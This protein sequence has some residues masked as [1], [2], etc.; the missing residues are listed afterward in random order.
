[1]DSVMNIMFIETPIFAKYREEYMPDDIFQEFEEYLSNNPEAGDIV[2]GTGGC[3]KI[4]WQREN[5]GKSSG[6]R[7][8]YYYHHID[9]FILL[10][11]IYPKSKK[12]SLNN[13]EKAL[14]KEIVKGLA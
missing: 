12:D 4:R 6:V 8:I 2:V 14:L 7:V 10:L 9:K 5:T 11:L 13:Q 1:M 3:R